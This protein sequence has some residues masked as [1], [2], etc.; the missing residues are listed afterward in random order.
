M[1]C[2]A[3][4]KTPSPTEVTVWKAPTTPEVMSSATSPPKEVAWSKIEPT[5]DVRLLDEV[6]SAERFRCDLL[7]SGK[8]ISG[9]N[10]LRVGVRVRCG[11]PA[12]HAALQS[13]R[14]RPDHL[15]SYNI[16]I[17]PTPRSRTHSMMPW[18]F[19]TGALG[20]A[21]AA[22]ARAGRRR[23]EAR[24]VVDSS[25]VVG[26]ARVSRC[27]KRKMAGE[28][29][30][31]RAPFVSSVMMQVDLHRLPSS[32]SAVLHSLLVRSLVHPDVMLQLFWL[33]KPPRR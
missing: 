16:L 29:P 9:R 6:R 22:T 13:I 32:L 11:F 17:R 8:L 10:E 25:V 7:R 27:R 4:V 24:I 1:S 26:G 28:R 31:W 14:H 21:K 30:A 18:R 19:S 3:Y 15:Q 23:M 2:R 20:A 33:A 5:P 12:P